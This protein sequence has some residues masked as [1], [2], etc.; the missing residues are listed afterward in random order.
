[1]NA[2][3]YLS[4]ESD[5]VATEDVVVDP[6]FRVFP[7]PFHNEALVTWSNTANTT[8]QIQ[9]LNV[10]GQLIRRYQNVQGES[11][12]IEKRDLLPGLYFLSMIDEAGNVG[13]VKILVQ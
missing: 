13:T 3:R 8:Y 9:L 6:D 5:V 2:T 1:M 4:I 12:R 10:T 11:L 7:N